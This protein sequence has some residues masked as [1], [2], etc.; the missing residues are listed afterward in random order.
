MKIDTNKKTSVDLQTSLGAWRL[1]R[2]GNKVR[3]DKSIWPVKLRVKK[4]K[5]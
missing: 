1:G 4:Y 2:Y 5:W 3:G